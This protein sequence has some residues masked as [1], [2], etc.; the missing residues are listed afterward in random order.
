[1]HG[2]AKGSTSYEYRT[3]AA[4]VADVPGFL[5]AQSRAV[6]HDLMARHAGEDPY[7]V[8]EIYLAHFAASRRE[9]VCAGPL[10]PWM[11]IAEW[12]SGLSSLNVSSPSKARW[13]CCARKRTRDL[14]PGLLTCLIA[15]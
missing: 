12:S 15:P 11:P 14:R 13:H 4:L 8:I 1:M 3:R 7:T 5:I 9:H 2:I 10:W 6:L